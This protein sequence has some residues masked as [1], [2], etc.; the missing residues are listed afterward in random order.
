LDREIRCT[1]EALK[2]VLA[3]YAF[4]TLQGGGLGIGTATERNGS[5]SILR[6]LG[7]RPLEW[8]GCAL[9]PYFDDKFGCRMEILRF[10][11]RCPSSRY[12]GA[13]LE[14]RSEIARLPVICPCPDNK[15]RGIAGDSIPAFADRQDPGRQGSLIGSKISLAA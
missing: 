4:A 14:L 13:I 12:A 3:I 15:W 9:P 5:S 10:D 11:S 6:R 2:S 1:T 8:D 7:G